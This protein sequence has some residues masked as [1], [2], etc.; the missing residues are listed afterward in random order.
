MLIYPLRT[1]PGGN[2]LKPKHPPFTEFV[3]EDWSHPLPET[4][5]EVVHLLHELPAGFIS[6][7]GFGLGLDKE[8][9]PILDAVRRVKGVTSLVLRDDGPRGPDGTRFCMTYDEYD[10][11]RRAM[12]RVTSRYRAEAKAD[13][14]IL[15]HNEM[16]T[17]LDPQRF[18]EAKRNY[19][20]GTVF[21]L[22]ARRSDDLLLSRDDGRALVLTLSV[23]A[24]TLARDPKQLFALGETVEKVSL[25]LLIA[26]LEDQLAKGGSEAQWQRLCSIR[27]LSILSLVFGYP[28]VRL[29]SQ[30]A[31]GGWRLKGGAKNRRLC[32]QE[33]ADP[34]R[35]AG[36]TEDAGHAVVDGPGLSSRRAERV[37]QA[38]RRGDAGARSAAEAAEE[39]EPDQGR[40]KRRGGP[41][42]GSAWDRL[43]RHRRP[44]PLGSEGDQ[45]ALSC[46][47]AA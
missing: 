3:L 28:I 46:S 21:K 5:E 42:H 31:V 16:L 23:A 47:V 44:A 35:C 10:D 26:K 19:A 34:R 30:G 2:F 14:T 11:L 7:P 24:P 36:G 15:A 4:P 37:A 32:G 9:W 40:G 43:H 33:P 27:T 20:P 12:H 1:W 39:P 22:L 6:D 17:A 38:Y 29:A 8:F 18:P 41:E 45:K 13:R 25:E